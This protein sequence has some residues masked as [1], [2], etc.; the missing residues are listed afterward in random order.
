MR[1]LGVGL[2]V[3][4]L[5]FALFAGLLASKRE[6]FFDP[7][8]YRTNYPCSLEARETPGP[9]DPDIESWFAAP[10]RS[11]GERPLWNA[12]FDGKTTLRFTFL[13]AFVEPV[14]VRI[15]DLYGPSPRL[16]A[17]RHVDQVHVDAGPDH[18]VR[19]LSKEDVAPLIALIS[20]SAVLDLA[21]DS[22]ISG[23]DGA[24]YL[25]EANG[26][27][28]YRFINRWSV[29][30]GAVYDLANAMYRLTGWPNGRQG[31]DRSDIDWPPRT[32]TAES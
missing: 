32:D 5:A 27:S 26:P 4:V 25:I 18:F 1:G 8:L 13:P 17:T 10:L 22:C 20:N 30:E 28:G 16:T 29:E 14:I 9:L 12:K 24:V 11:V 7:V 3:L 2:T 31:P 15:D 23:V 21:P 19:D 6:G